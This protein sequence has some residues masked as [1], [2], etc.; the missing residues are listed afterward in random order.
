MAKRSLVGGFYYEGQRTRRQML[1]FTKK[2]KAF[3]S[4]KEFFSPKTELNVN[5]IHKNVFDLCCVTYFHNQA[6][7]QRQQQQETEKLW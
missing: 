4:L 1:M 5:K 3:F 2:V 6:E 7:I